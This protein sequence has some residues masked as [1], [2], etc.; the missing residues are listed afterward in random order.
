MPR[1]FRPYDLEQRSALPDK[2]DTAYIC[3]RCGGWFNASSGVAKR[4]RGEV[5]W[6]NLCNRCQGEPILGVDYD[7]VPDDAQAK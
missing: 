2:Y 5:R 3:S 6:Q 4:M 1:V 7:E